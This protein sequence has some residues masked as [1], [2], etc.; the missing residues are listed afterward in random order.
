MKSGPFEF[1]NLD[2]GK[3][4]KTGETSPQPS[5]ES[6]FGSFGSFAGEGESENES[7]PFP[8][9]MLPPILL[10]MAREV[11]KVA[12]VPESLAVINLL[13]FVSSSLGGGLLIDSGGGRITPANLFLLGIAESGTGKGRAFSIV[14]EAFTKVET[15]EIDHWETEGL[16]SVKKDLRLIEKDFKGLE[17]AI[18][19]EQPAGGGRPSEALILATKQ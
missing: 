12:L 13:G 8:V 10:E 5:S 15:E 17:K 14:S 11:S 18:E 7:L 3:T 1:K 19:K 4:P 6:S 16:P 2:S 9:E